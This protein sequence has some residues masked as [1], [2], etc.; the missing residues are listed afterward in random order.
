MLKYFVRDMYGAMRF[1]PMGLL[2]GMLAAAAVRMVN[3]RRSGKGGQPIRIVPATCFCV[4]LAI[5]F[6]ITLLSRESGAGKRLDLE[7]FSTFGINSRNNAYVAEN[8]LLFLPYGFIC[9]WN[10][11]KLRNFFLCAGTGLLTSLGVETLQLISRRGI[12]QIDDILTNLLGSV[13]GWTLFTAGRLAG[14][15]VRRRL[16]R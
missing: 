9:P 3:I 16:R 10:F 5:I 14:Q 2:I 13:A 8:I 6:G 12:F 1:L 7:L 11:K 15:A 4:S